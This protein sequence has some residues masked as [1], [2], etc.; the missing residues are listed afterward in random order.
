M[1]GLLVLLPLAA[2]ALGAVRG[3]RARIALGLPPLPSAGARPAAALVALGVVVAAAAAQPVWSTDRAA[4]L[5]GDAAAIL[6]VDTSRSMLAAAAPGAPTRLERARRLALALRERLADV[7]LG[8]ASLSDRAL[9]HLFPSGDPQAFAGVLT[10]TIRAG[11]PE[12]VSVETLGTDLSG[13]ASVPRDNFFEPRHRRR[14]VIALTDAETRPL[15]ADA[16]TSGFRSV[17]RATLLL[18]RVGSAREQVWDAR[19]FPERDYAADPAAPQLARAAADL[20]G[21]VAFDER[22]VDAVVAAARRALG[23]GPR[24]L[25][26][27]DAEHRTPL[28]AWVLAL[29]LV[30]LGFL[31][32]VRNRG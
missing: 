32:A 14:V 17:P 24:T 9:P 25:P 6:V 30:P 4:E 31:V 21:G 16:L 19:G 26:R 12:P 20:A 1:L 8:I 23:D 7:P 27:G 22:G 13:L 2:L 10:R 3:A 28:A 11:H 18:V 5:R 15:D 29:G